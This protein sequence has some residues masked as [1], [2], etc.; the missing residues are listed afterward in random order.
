MA[1]QRE[2]GENERVE[3]NMGAEMANRTK[4]H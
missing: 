1:K 4:P 3:R 2:Q